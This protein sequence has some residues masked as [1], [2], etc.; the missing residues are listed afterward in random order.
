MAADER[1]E[2]YQSLNAKEKMLKPQRRATV[3]FLLW[4]TVLT[5]AVVTIAFLSFDPRAGDQFQ[6]VYVLA[7]YSFA[8]SLFCPC[9]TNFYCRV[10]PK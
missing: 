8:T 5:W 10:R 9:R 1:R 7:A 4:A 6:A 3:F 2:I